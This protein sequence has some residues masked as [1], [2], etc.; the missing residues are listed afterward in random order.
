MPADGGGYHIEIDKSRQILMIAENGTTR[1]TFNTSTGSEVP[2]NE[3]G[4][5]GTAVTPTGN[6]TVCHERDYLRESSLGTLWRPKYFQCAR[7]I[8]VHGATSVPSYPASHGC[9]RVT[10]PAMNFIWSQ[11]MMPMGTRVYVYGSIPG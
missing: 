8:A 6:F 4:G 5:S 9:V 7:G 10:Y 3:E 1:W 2:Y 11:D